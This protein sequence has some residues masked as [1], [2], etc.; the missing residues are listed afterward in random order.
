MPRTPAQ[1]LRSGLVWLMLQPLIPAAASPPTVDV[2]SSEGQFV[3]SLI[4]KAFQS[5]PA[6]NQTVLTEMTDEGRK[7]PPTTPGQPAYYVL[8]PAG[9]HIEGEDIGAEPP[10][11][12]ELLAPHLQRALAVNGY[13][14]AAGPHP[15]SLLIVFHWGAHNTLGDDMPDVGHRNLLSRAALIG[16]EK[17]AEDLRK[18][19]NQQDRDDMISADTPMEFRGLLTNFGAVRRFTDRDAKTQ[20]LVEEAK[21]EC[22]YV[23]AS[24]YDYAAAAKGKRVLLWRSKMTVDSTGVNMAETLPSVIQNAGRYFGRDMT[25]VAT[26]LRPI[27]REEQVR[28]GPLEV[29][30]YIPEKVP[31]PGKEAGKP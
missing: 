4:P 17:F 1:L 22:Y 3:F 15:P 21:A 19:L 10:P 11:P 18:A 29:Q 12:P 7:L 20:H 24:A 25:E 30:E 6:V 28:L 13:R 2:E 31:Q 27:N 23:V 14:P 5:H 16:G 8:Q 26:I 9:Y